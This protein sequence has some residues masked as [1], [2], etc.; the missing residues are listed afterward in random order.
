MP[1]RY[2]IVPTRLGPMGAVRSDAGLCAV[3]LPGPSEKELTHRLT[4]QHPEAA[5]DDA[6]FADLS[7]QCER[8]FDGAAV[9]FDLPV[10]LSALTPFR[11]KVLTALRKIGFGQKLTYAD[12][13][14]RVGKPKAARAVGGAMAANPVPL[15]VPCHRVVASDGGLGGYSGEGGITLKQ[16]LL[17]LEAAPRG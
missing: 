12:L 13:A 15:V 11:R 1:L 16:R 3:I 7:E 14:K 5:R 17:E 4:Q 8:Y 10:D 6:A 2:G 9:D